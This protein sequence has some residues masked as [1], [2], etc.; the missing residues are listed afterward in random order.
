MYTYII[1]P[2]FPDPGSTSLPSDGPI[3]CG[4]RR[5]RPDLD[6]RNMT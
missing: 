6:G 5:G 3:L 1:S 4:R 2:L